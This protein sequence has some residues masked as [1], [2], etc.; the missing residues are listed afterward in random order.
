MFDWDEANISHIARHSITP[1][2][3]E[4]VL[5]NDPLELMV[6]IHGEEERVLQVGVTKALRYLV[7]VTTW[8]E[9]RLRVVTAY[10]APRVLR[11]KYVQGQRRS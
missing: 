1:E 10:E 7:V 9:E 8:R 4:H 5:L 11:L 2:E 3:A 6:Q